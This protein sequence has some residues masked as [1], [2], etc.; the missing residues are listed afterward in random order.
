MSYFERSPDGES[1]KFLTRLDALTWTLIYGGLLTP[2]LGLWVESGDDDTSW[3]LVTAG[4]VAAATGIV[5]IYVR[6]R[7]KGQP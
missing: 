6:S 5:L 1:N 7:I 4:T 3:L 2:I